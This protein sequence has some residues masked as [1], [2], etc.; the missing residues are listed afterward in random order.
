MEAPVID[1]TF[2]MAERGNLSLS[3]LRVSALWPVRVARATGDTKAMDSAD[4]TTNHYKHADTQW[5][6]FLHLSVLMEM[7]GEWKSEQDR[8]CLQQAVC[9]MDGV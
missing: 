1:G 5:G 7:L 2:G 6:H 8:D 9:R 4:E 3:S